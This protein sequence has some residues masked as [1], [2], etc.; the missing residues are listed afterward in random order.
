MRKKHYWHLDSKTITLYQSEN[1]PKFYKEIPLSDIL[2]IEPGST[3]TAALAAHAFQ[4][5]TDQVIITDY[6]RHGF[7]ISHSSASFSC[8]EIDQTVL[9]DSNHF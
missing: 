3:G 8:A 6:Q 7:S 4:L 1:D 2:S 5:R 9:H